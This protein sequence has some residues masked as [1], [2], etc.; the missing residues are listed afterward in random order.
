MIRHSLGGF[1]LLLAIRPDNCVLTTFWG[2]LIGC[3][4]G[5]RLQTEVIVQ[6]A[7][8]ATVLRDTA[9]HDADDIQESFSTFAC[10][11]ACAHVCAIMG[12]PC[13]SSS[14][15]PLSCGRLSQDGALEMPVGE[16]CMHGVEERW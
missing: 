3:K 8:E 13:R 9:D 4:S 11:V 2:L 14:G 1:Y 7:A 5:P 12:E 10:E 16:Q 15:Q 6:L